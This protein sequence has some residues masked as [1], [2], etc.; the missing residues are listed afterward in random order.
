MDG[1]FQSSVLNWFLILLGAFIIGLSKAGVKGIDMLNVTLMALVFGGKASFNR[2]VWDSKL[3][4][5][6]FR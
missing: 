4:I 6:C 3:T 2:K 5:T 1:L